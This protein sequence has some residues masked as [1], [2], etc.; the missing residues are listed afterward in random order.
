MSE[1]AT[2]LST[3]TSFGRKKPILVY[4]LVMLLLMVFAAT[5]AVKTYQQNRQAATSRLN[6]RADLAS[7][8]VAQAFMASDY[9]LQTLAGFIEPLARISHEKAA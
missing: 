4:L 6:A 3:T 2:S 9:G 8:L 1:L 5:V 7:E